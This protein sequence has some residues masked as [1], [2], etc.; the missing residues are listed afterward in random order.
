M[1]ADASTG[2]TLSP[3]ETATTMSGTITPGTGYAIYQFIGT[4]GETVNLTSDSFSSTSG[5]WFVVD[6]YDNQLASASFGTSFTASLSITGLY[7]LV[8]SG[9]DQPIKT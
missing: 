9:G 5:N 3:G 4:A 8:F 7:T 2:T 6:P 1:L